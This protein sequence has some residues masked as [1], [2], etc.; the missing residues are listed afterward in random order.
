M[1]IIGGGSL[2]ALDALNIFIGAVNDTKLDIDG[3][4]ALLPRLRRMTTDQ[5]ALLAAIAGTSDVLMRKITPESEGYTVS[6]A[7]N[8]SPNGD[9]T[10]REDVQ[11]GKASFECQIGDNLWSIWH[12]ENGWAFFIMNYLSAVGTTP[13]TGGY[14][15]ATNGGQEHIITGIY[16]AGGGYSGSPEVGAG[17][18]GYKKLVADGDA[19]VAKPFSGVILCPADNSGNTTFRADSNVVTLPKGT[20]FPVTRVLLNDIEV[21]GTAGDDVLVY[22]G[23]W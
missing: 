16:V 1:A 8:P 13:P 17:P 7:G 9:Y 10:D 12:H 20:I 22:G 15:Q 14:F 5:G 6:G 23:S 3:N 21:K 18:V 4:G 11:G 19:W 2:S